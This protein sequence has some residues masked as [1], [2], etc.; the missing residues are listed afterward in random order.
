MSELASSQAFYELAKSGRYSKTWLTNKIQQMQA[1]ENQMAIIQAL[2]NDP[3]LKYYLGVML[4]SATAV[5][6]AMATGTITP[7]TQSFAHKQG[8]G[9]E[10]T[11]APATKFT[12]QQFEETVP[13]DQRRGWYFSSKIN[14]WI[15][16]PQGYY[17]NLRTGNV[18]DEEGLQKE[19][20]E[21]QD[22][23]DPLG[24]HKVA[25]NM[26][27]IMGMFNNVFSLAGAGFAGWCAA[28]LLLKAIFGGDGLSQ[29]P[30]S[31][32]VL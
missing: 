13:L 4:G 11:F 24:F 19:R 30:F 1:H 21:R 10:T 31:G 6:G 3:E 14:K 29:L 22:A 20:E 16:V 23:A 12:P 2:Q 5:V 26:T 9:D 15:Y 18:V 27:D 17:L 7:A 25:G 8:E 32:G 28:V